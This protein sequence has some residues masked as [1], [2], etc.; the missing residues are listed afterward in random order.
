M[1]FSHTHIGEHVPSSSNNYRA[2][3]QKH[4]KYCIVYIH[5][6]WLNSKLGFVLLVSRN[7]TKY[8]L[9]DID[10]INRKN[11]DNAW[12]D[13]CQTVYLRE[14]MLRGILPSFVS[15]AVSPQSLHFV[16]VL[17]HHLTKIT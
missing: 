14:N 8:E 4:L 16:C 1:E 2:N 15:A 7:V 5:I 12:A 10:N 13:I 6:C 17:I 9:I 3:F 11:T